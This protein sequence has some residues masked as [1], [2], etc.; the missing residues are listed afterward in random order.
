MPDL[1]H[2]CAMAISFCLSRASAQFSLIAAASAGGG[3]RAGVEL[4][5]ISNIDS[6]TD[7]RESNFIDFNALC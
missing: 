6:T 1:S 3:L 7:M 5:A 4:H 2:Q